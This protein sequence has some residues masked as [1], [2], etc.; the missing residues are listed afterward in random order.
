M[1]LDRRRVKFWQKWVFGIMVVTMVAFLVMIPVGGQLGCG[2]PSVDEQVAAE[3]EK[4][5]QTL[6]ASPDDVDAL[7]GLGNEYVVRANQSESDS[8]EYRGDLRRAIELYEKAAVALSKTEGGDVLNERVDVLEQ[9]ASTYVLLGEYQD[10]ANVYVRV[11]KLTPR[12]A[13]AYFDW[14]TLA[15]RAGDTKTALLAFTRFLELDPESPYAADVKAWIKE[16]TP[17]P[18]ALP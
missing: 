12:D 1:L 17:K 2:G 6:A 15:D 4:Y 8:P 13:V 11:T 5:E 7:R 3:I 14:A 10:A 16:N 18:T 9:I